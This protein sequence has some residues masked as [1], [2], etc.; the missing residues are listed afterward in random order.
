MAPKWLS[1][2]GDAVSDRWSRLDRLETELSSGDGQTFHGR[3]STP[4]PDNRP[5]LY[6]PHGALHTE[7]GRQALIS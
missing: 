3:L 7:A 2:V 4:L 5:A 6:S 1:V